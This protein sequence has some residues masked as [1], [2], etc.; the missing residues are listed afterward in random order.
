[1]TQT[2]FPERQEQSVEKSYFGEMR[3]IC[4]PQE[5]LARVKKFFP[6]FGI[7]RVANITGLDCVGVPVY[8]A[9]R[10]NS[11]ALSVSQGKGYTHAAAQAS[12]VME[13]IESYHA[14]T[15]DRPLLLQ[16]YLDMRCGRAVAD[17]DRLPRHGGSAYSPHR[18]LLWMQGRDIMN[19]EDKW[20][21]HECVHTDYRVPLP[22]GHGCFVSSSNG[23]ASGNNYYEAVLHGLC[24]VIERD[25]LTLWSMT[26]GADAATKVDP[27]TVDDVFCRE[28]INKLEAAGLKLGIWEITS[29]L[30]IPAFLCR[31]VPE[32]PPDIAAQRPASGMGCHLHP[33]IALLR[34]LTEAAQS[35][36][37][38]I[39]GARDDMSRRD[40]ARFLG[41]EEYIK[42]RGLID[43]PGTLHYG[44]IHTRETPYLDTDIRYILGR[45]RARGIREV[46]AVDLTKP[47]IGIDVTK[48]IVPGLESYLS[49]N[50]LL[51]ERGSRM[52][53]ER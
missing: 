41:E 13:S 16:S 9:C 8:T 36:L 19:E 1:M 4:P 39:A 38:F 37:T 14:E 31:I 28:V 21:P 18:R 2:R 30:S 23:L 3:R 43:R 7:T 48:V 15:I 10:P 26:P 42:W 5:T 22:E 34:A 53:Q 44:A 27:A 46:I 6:V 47:H 29:D 45:L 32:N 12:A 35:R 11:R 49:P 40:Y 24:E 52:L 51:G 25:A 33:G 20:V 50:M 17:I